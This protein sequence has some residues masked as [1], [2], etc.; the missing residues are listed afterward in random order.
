NDEGRALA[1]AVAFRADTATMQLDNALDDRQAEPGRALATRRFGG[2]ALETTEQARHVVR[3][4]PGALVLDADRDAT[5]V[6]A[7][8][9]LHPASDWRV[10][11]RVAHQVVDRFAHAVRIAIADLVRW[12]HQVN[13]LLFLLGQRPVGHYDF[14][15]HGGKINGLMADRNVERI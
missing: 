11:D 10:L 3:R 15:Q 4:E 13:V 1:G 5:A 14:A 12:R 8:R 6:N 9:Q 7:H 2:Q